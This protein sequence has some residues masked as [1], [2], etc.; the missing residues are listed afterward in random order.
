MVCTR[1]PRVLFLALLVAPALALNDAE[2][3]ASLKGTRIENARSIEPLY[4]RANES[5]RIPAV[6]GMGLGE[7]NIAQ[8]TVNVCVVN[9]IYNT[10]ASSATRVEAWLPDEDAWYGRIMG[11]GGGGLG[12]CI[13]YDDLKWGPALHFATF[14]H[15]GGHDGPSGAAFA[16]SDEIVI[17]YASRG[18]HV[19]ALTTKALVRAYYGRTQ[20]K[21]YYVGCSNGGRQ[22]LRNAQDN[23]DDFDGILAGAPAYNLPHL[24]AL[25]NIANLAAHKLNDRDWALVREEV[26]RQCDGLDGVNDEII[27][28][29]DACQF[30]P[31]TLL[32][33]GKKRND[34]LSIEQVEAVRTIHSPL[35]GDQGQLLAPRYDP[36]VELSSFFWPLIFGP[37][38]YQFGQ[39]WWQYV[40]YND[41]TWE[42]SANFGFKEIADADARDAQLPVSSFNPDLSAFRER[43]GKLLTY[44]GLRD[45]LIPSGGSIWYYQMVQRALSLTPGRMDEFYR[46][47]LVPGMDHCYM[48]VGAWQIGQI[49]FGAYANSS[50]ANA[51]LA[52]VDWVEKGAG[53]ETLRGSRDDTSNATT[54][55]TRLHCKY[56][57]RS[58][59]KAELNDWVCVQYP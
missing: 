7:D 44:H 37:G 8:T 55:V 28:D 21:T 45:I 22:G 32:C 58:I 15:D 59:W 14:G 5:Y 54:P 35:Y 23:P 25:S 2:R 29:P 26:L 34:C 40:V 19:A 17:D 51:L 52:L 39:E 27:S 3:C 13:D 42:P 24:F 12:G 41:N 48:G 16:Q 18:L 49:S 10:S 9:V 31:E 56:P 43:G 47:F 11:T 36:G 30:L 6:C 38:F 53:P 33:G 50:D 1:L 46:L 4:L 20:D 57:A